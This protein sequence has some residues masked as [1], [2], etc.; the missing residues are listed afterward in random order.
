MRLLFGK[1]SPLCASAARTRSRASLT[2]VSARPTSVK[3]GR[4]LARCTSTCTAGASR[5]SI[6]R[7]ATTANVM[8]LPAPA[9]V[10]VACLRTTG[11]LG[12]AHR[13]AVVI[14]RW[15][16][17]GRRPRRV[18][19][20]RKH[21]IS[22]NCDVHRIG[23]RR[24][25]ASGRPLPCRG[26][27]PRSGARHGSCE[28]RVSRTTFTST[29]WSRNRHDQEDR[30]L[31]TRR[32]AGR[33]RRRHVAY[34]DVAFNVGAVTD[35]RYRGI[36]QTRGE[37]ALQGGVD[38]QQRPLLRRRLGLEHQVDQGLRRRR[39]RRDRPLRRLQGRDHQGA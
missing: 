7:L 12:A 8:S 36:S 11:I 23:A 26:A 10:A 16:L 20:M 25:R 6:A 28:H 32:G 37:P 31:R 3:L 5:P 22:A 9:G 13:G 29:H 21:R 1:P 15:I 2:S 38:Y 39:R 30:L 17:A 27:R 18:P 19:P 34:A 14:E 35:Y 24:A 4:P 33:L